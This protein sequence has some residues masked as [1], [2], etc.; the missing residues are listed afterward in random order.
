MSTAER[1]KPALVIGAL[2]VVYGDIG[3]SPIYTFRESLKAAGEAPGRG[4][5]LGLLSLIFWTLMVVVTI[6]YVVFVMRAD[7]DGEGGIMA[8]LGL[9][10]GAEPNPR[11]A[12]FLLVAG[13][14]GAALFYGD[15]MITPAI[16]VLSAVEGLDVA[17]TIFHPYV[18]PLTLVILVTLFVVQSKGSAVIGAFF[19]PVMAIWFTVIAAVGLIQI[20]YKPVVLLALDPSHALRFLAG[21]IGVALP[22]LGSVFLAVTGAEALYADMGHFGR[23]PIRFAWFAFV[24]PALVLNYFGQGA[25]VLSDPGSVD[26][27]F[28]RLFPTWALYPAVIL[29]AA[30]TV[31]ASQAVISGAFSLSQQAMQLSLL[32]RLDVRQTSSESIGQVY[33]PQINWLLMF[34]VIGLVL[35]FRSSDALASAYGIAVSG[36]MLVTTLLLGVVAHYLWRWNAVAIAAVLGV[37]AVVDAMF[38]ISNSL[39]ILDGGWFPLLVGAIAFTLMSTWRRGRELILQRISE[40]NIPIVRFLSERAP[41]LPRVSGTGIYLSSRRDKVPYA[42]A[43]NVRHNKVLHER[44]ALLTVVTERVPTVSEDARMEVEDL[45]SG[46][47]R[48]VLHFGFAERP[49]VPAALEAHHEQ[50]AI[51]MADAS[52]FVGRELP[53]PTMRPDLALWRE[54]LFTFMTRNAVGASSYFNIP[55]KRVVELGV[56]VEL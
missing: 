25:L 19:G 10:R 56:Q 31:I 39:K 11:L 17:T 5:V 1:L 2:G 33:V 22:V 44:A 13:I 8:L 51:D 34:A 32:P 35:G 52:F 6:K 20:A 54:H 24:L 50:Y 29:A 14:A 37:L 41:K 27:P 18:V 40:D 9:A 26:S 28:Y 38:F 48:V 23:K 55:P 42:L 53:I 43:D 36:T 47:S 16:S 30:A 15:G 46:F 4:V 12:R 3:T 49:D 7:N 45:G 21:H